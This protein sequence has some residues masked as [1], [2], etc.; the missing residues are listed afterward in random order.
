MI[1]SRPHQKIGMEKPVSEMPINVWSKIEPRLT[2]AM[3]PA[4]RPI[5][6]AMS[7]AHSDSSTVAGNRV[8][9]SWRIGWRVTIELPRSPCARSPRKIEY[10][11]QSGWSKP[12]CACSWAWRSG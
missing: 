3:M 5:E 2:P 11:C 9:N 7:R 4:G 10:C 6:V 8:K 12:N 1:S